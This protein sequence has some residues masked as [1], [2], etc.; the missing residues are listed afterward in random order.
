MFLLPPGVLRSHGLIVQL[1]QPGHVLGACAGGRCC[2]VSG[3]VSSAGAGGRGRSVEDDVGDEVVDDG[4]AW[5][6]DG[7]VGLHIRR[8]IE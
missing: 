8:H 6:V 1:D 2:S 3:V 5:R 7:W 4:L